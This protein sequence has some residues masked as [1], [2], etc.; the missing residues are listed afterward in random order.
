[1]DKKKS[2]RI[3]RI[4]FFLF[5]LIIMITSVKVAF[6]LYDLNRLA[7]ERFPKCSRIMPSHIYA[8]PLDIRPEIDLSAEA[9][10][11]ELDF[12]EPLKIG[13][14]DASYRKS[15]IAVQINDVPELLIRTITAVEDRYFFAHQGG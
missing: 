2:W 9:F 6:F 8:R 15:G 5:F 12:L 3:L 10:A 13:N 14:L 1:M 7:D 4:L 11:R